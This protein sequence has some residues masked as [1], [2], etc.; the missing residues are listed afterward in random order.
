MTEPIDFTFCE[1]LP[2][3]AYNG[4]NDIILYIPF[5]NLAKAHFVKGTVKVASKMENTND[6]RI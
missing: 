1:R 4:A 5:F 3:R 2:G 6:I